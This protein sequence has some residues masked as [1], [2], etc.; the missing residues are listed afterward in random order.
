M[1]DGSLYGWL[2]VLPP[3]V[4]IVAALL[5][6]RVVVPLLIVNIVRYEAEV[7]GRCISLKDDPQLAGAAPST[8]ES[9]VVKPAA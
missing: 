6:R 4:A 1:E 2:S 7:R 8:R 9:S 3:L 5:L